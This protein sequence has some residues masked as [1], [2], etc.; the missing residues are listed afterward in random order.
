MDNVNLMDNAL[1]DSFA[2][3][4]ENNYRSFHTQ[5]AYISD[6]KEFLNHSK[7]FSEREINRYIIHL[8]KKNI[9]NRSIRR[10]L[11]SISI[12][13]EFLKKNGNIKNNPMEFIIKPKMDKNLPKF[14]DI[15]ETLQLLEN[16]SNTRDRALLELVYSSSL[17]ASETMGLNIED[18]DFEHLRIRIMRK[19]GKTTYVPVT[20]RAKKYLK[21]Y[22]DKRISGA[23]FLNKYGNRLSTRS[24]QTIVKKYAMHNIFKDISPHTMRHTKATHLIN[25]GMDIRIL[26]KLLGHSSIRATQIYTH[27][28]LKE[29]METYDRAH[30]LEKDKNSK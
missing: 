14:L 19:G 10:K 3:F 6:V 24:L 8:S 1:L 18:I 7:T 26:Q 12:F 28:N 9:S 2:A 11:S 5:R 4:I 15:D 22:I 16:I 27:L 25:S 30:P 13:F 21:I 17:R 20:Q 23:V 29:L